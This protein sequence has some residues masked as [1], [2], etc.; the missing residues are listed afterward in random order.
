[1]AR[2]CGGLVRIWAIF[3]TPPAL[4]SLAFKRSYQL[5]R[6]FDCEPGAL[7]VL[8]A[9]QLVGAGSVLQTIREAVRRRERLSIPKDKRLTMPPGVLRR[10]L[11]YTE[12]VSRSLT[13]SQTKR[14]IDSRRWR[15]TPG[16]TRASLYSHSS[17]ARLE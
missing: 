6:V 4:N 11:A 3:R 9:G 16:L 14:G 15:Q 12:L 8:Q 7:L 13:T 1:M 5:S 17:P 2:V 10:A